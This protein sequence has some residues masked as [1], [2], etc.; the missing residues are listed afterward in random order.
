MKLHLSNTPQPSL[1]SSPQEDAGKAEE[2]TC[3]PFGQQKHISVQQQPLWSITVDFKGS[4]QDAGYDVNLKAPAS[5]GPPRA[6]PIPI[7]RKEEDQGP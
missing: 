7:R 1:H 6:N 4:Q 5:E 3:S 2:S